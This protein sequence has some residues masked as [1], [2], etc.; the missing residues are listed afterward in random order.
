MDSRLKSFGLALGPLSFLLLLLIPNPEAISSDAWMVMALAAF[1]MVWWITQ[2]IPMAITALLPVIMIPALDIASF[3]VAI[4]SYTHPVVFLLIGSFC[5]A[6]AAQKSGLHKR[7][8]LAIMSLTSRGSNTVVLGIMA[9]S[10][11][12]SMWISNTATAALMLPIGLAIYDV[13]KHEIKDHDPERQR[14]LK[15][16]I[17]L[18][19]AYGANIGGTATLIGAPTN[20][21]AA[22][23]VSQNLDIAI[24]FKSWMMIGVPFAACMML[25]GWAVLTFIAYPDHIGSLKSARPLVRKEIDKLGPF[26]F[27]EKSIAAIFCCAI[28]MWLFKGHLPFAMNDASIALAAGIACFALP[29]AR[30][31]KQPLLQSEDMGAL[32]WPILFIF[33]GGLALASTAQST[34]LVDLVASPLTSQEHLTQWL[35][36][37]LCI[38]FVLMITEVVGNIAVITVMLPILA[39][40]SGNLGYDPLMVIIPATL[41]ASC[42]FMLPISTP[43]NTVVFSSG[44][45]RV[46]Q[47]MRAGAALNIVAIALLFALAVLWIPLIV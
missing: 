20:A 10:A 21:I 16:K 25:V 9:S 7:I 41:A 13:I 26:S 5:M 32:P 2:A 37:L 45:I 22:A 40:L 28:L 8:A 3:K 11:F 15:T 18:G 1:M 43:P 30:N 12:I 36:I 14:R 23:F 35:L 39:A 42:A 19:V 29:L 24:S 44:S 38:C 46:T 47:M 6:A 31:K 4:G 27:E 17:I 34:G 33:C